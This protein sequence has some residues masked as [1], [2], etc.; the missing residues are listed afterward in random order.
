MRFASSTS[1]SAES[2]GTLPMSL[3]YIFTESSK[4]PSMMVS[5]SSSLAD[6]TVMFASSSALNTPS[7]SSALAPR[8][9]RRAIISSSEMLPLERPVSM[10]LSVSCF[11][12]CSL[13]ILPP[14]GVLFLCFSRARL[15]PLPP[16]DGAS[17]RRVFSSVFAA[18]RLAQPLYLPQDGELTFAVGLLLHL[19]PQSLDLVL[20]VLVG[21]QLHAVEIISPLSVRR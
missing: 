4:L 14:D 6:T 20:P 5:M 19:F 15:P 18:R 10:S 9:S 17:A 11:K 8:C 12:S 21:E 13:S 3:R 1:F 16:S 7:R 2:R